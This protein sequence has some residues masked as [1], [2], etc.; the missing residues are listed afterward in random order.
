MK[1]S[2]FS[3]GNDWTGLVARL[4]V[5]I[6]LLPHGAQKMLGMFGGYGF[7]ATMD[8]L[9][10]PSH[11]LPS[12]IA[13]FVIVIEFA[14]PL[15]LLAGFAVRLWAGAIILLMM[16][17]IIS[18]HLDYGF[19]MNWFGNQKGEGY[20]YHLL[21]IGLALILLFNGSGRYAVDKKLAGFQ[22]PR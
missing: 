21:M 2:V 11:K 16:G 3:A 13:F 18:S 20:E 10:G 8:Y 12:V 4:I 22:K 19:F 7:S 17:I 15:A 14:G 9:T 1:R 6:V 5:G